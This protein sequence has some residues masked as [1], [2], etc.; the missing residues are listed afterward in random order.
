MT[1][2]ATFALCIA[3][4]FGAHTATADIA[5]SHD[6]PIELAG[7]ESF[8]FNVGISG[9]ITGFDYVFDF[10]SPGDDS[11]ASDILITII[12]PHDNTFLIGGFDTPNPDAV[13]AY[14]GSVS[15]HDGAYG[16]NLAVGGLSGAGNWSVIFTNDRAADLNPNILENIHFNIQGIGSLYP[17]APGTGAL[18]AIALTTFGVHRRR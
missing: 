4:L 3:A 16:D 15:G 9:T 2:I 12:D 13:P 10:Y 5:V 1:R 18:A 17:P 7:G 14:D 11:W 6:G 8:E